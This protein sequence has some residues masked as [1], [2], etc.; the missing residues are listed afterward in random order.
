[1]LYQD[2]PRIYTAIAEWGSCLVYLYILKKEN[3][4]SVHFLTGSLFMLAMQS[5]FLTLTGSV[6]EILWIPC[7]MIAAGMMY[8]FLMV[9]GNMKPLGAAYCCARAFVLAEFAASLQWQMVSI[10]QAWGN[11]SLGVEILITMVVF[12]GCFTIDIYLEKDLL[13]Q[14]YLEQM[15]VKEVVAAAIM[16]VAIF[17]FSN[18]SF[19]NENAPFASR[20][21]ADIF[22]MRTLIDFGGIAKGYT[23][24]RIMDIYKD[25][26]IT[27][28]LVNLGGNVQALGTKTDGTKWKIA[29]QSPDDT[30][31]YLGILSVQDKAVI[32]SGGYERYF[33]QDGVTYHHIIDPKTGYPAENG[34]VSVTIVSSDGTLADGLST[35]LFIM[36][37]EKAADF[38]R[39]H[40]DEFDAILMSDDGTLYVTEGLEN[41]FSTERTVEIIR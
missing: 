38:W 2:I 28:G 14:N 6:T 29:V 33:E 25:N 39:E 32:T 36:G 24:S 22:S 26:G 12:G 27:S 30:E 19:L 21:R 11:Q 3:M 15:T 1:M 7:M 37:E 10:V 35:S 34:L 17:A 40:K 8:G 18:L 41:D 5:I 9:G 13:K 20:E 4:K 23:S 16:A 31:D